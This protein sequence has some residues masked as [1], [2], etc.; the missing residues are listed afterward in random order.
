MRRFVFYP[1]ADAHG[2]IVALDVQVIVARLRFGGDQIAVDRRRNIDIS[3]NGAVREFDFEQVPAFAVTH[4][5]DA[6]RLNALARNVR[7]DCGQA[8]GILRF[9]IQRP[10]NANEKCKKKTAT[11][12]HG[13]ES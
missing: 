2:A 4:L 11:A 5:R 3:I 9:G 8:F 10:A 12:L 6:M 1:R 13:A 7:S